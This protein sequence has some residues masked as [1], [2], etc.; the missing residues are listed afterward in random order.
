MNAPP[1]PQERINALEAEVQTLKDRLNLL[2]S[3]VLQVKV[4]FAPLNGFVASLVAAALFALVCCSVFKDE[5]L[6]FY[7]YY[8]VPISIPFV[9]FLFERLRFYYRLPRFHLP[10]LVDAVVVG[11][12]LLRAV[13]ELPFISGHAFFLCFALL[14][15]KSNWARIPTLLVLCQ[16]IYLKIFAWQDATLWGGLAAA[17]LAACLWYFLP[18]IQQQINLRQS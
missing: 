6:R 18:K 14:T 2:E 15:V 17:L 7:L 5:Q 13:Y 12:S 4:L 3:N 8:F 10:L 1:S 11:L 16:V 9:C